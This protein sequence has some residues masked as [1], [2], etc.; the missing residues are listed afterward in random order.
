MPLTK[1]P[2]GSRT[3]IVNEPLA[4]CEV[5]D[6]VEHALG[7]SL[8]TRIAETDVEASIFY[9]DLATLLCKQALIGTYIILAISE[10]TSTL[11]ITMSLSLTALSRW[12]LSS[13]APF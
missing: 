4:A 11:F 1:E 10:N 7:E 2:R 6:D 13:M 8:D 5:N 3:A 9:R 12:S